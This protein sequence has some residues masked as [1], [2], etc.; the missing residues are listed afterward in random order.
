MRTRPPVIWNAT[1]MKSFGVNLEKHVKKVKEKRP[2]GKK[3]F[4]LD[5]RRDIFFKSIYY[6]GYSILQLSYKQYRYY[7]DTGIGQD[8]VFCIP[9]PPLK[10]TTWTFCQDTEFCN[11]YKVGTLVLWR[12][13]CTTFKL[14]L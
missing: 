10:A 11:K 7:L 8:T 13:I 14:Q 3:Y 2:D 9:P 6:S 1:L 5:C 12:R 4:G